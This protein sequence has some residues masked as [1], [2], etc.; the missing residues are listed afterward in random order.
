MQKLDPYINVD[1]GTMNP[2]QHGEVFVTDDKGETD[3][4][5][6]HYE[7]FVDVPLT[8]RSNATTG[9]IYQSVL[10][11]E[12]KGEYLGETVQVIPHITNEIKQRILALANDDVDV[13]ITEVGGTVGDIEILPFLEAIRQFRKDVGRENVFYVHVTLVPYIGPSGEQKTKPTQH[14]VTELRGRGIQPDAIVC[15]SDRPISK[16]LK[17]KISQLCDVPEA[18]IVTAVDADILYEIPLVLHDEGLDDYVCKVLHLDQHEAD[19][20]EWTALVD[21]VRAAQDDVRIGLVGKYINLPD[22]YL[23]V[24]EALKHGGYACGANVHIDWIAADDAEG[25]LAESRLHDLDGIVVPGGFGM[26]GI[27][28]KIEAA[29]YARRNAIPFLGLCLG[30]HCAVIE[31]ARDVCHLENANSSEFDPSTPHPVIDLMDE[32]K[33]VVDMGGTMRLGAYPAKLKA[34]SV[35]REIYGEEVV[36]E[37]HRHRYELNNRYRQVFEEHGMVLSGTSP[38]DLLVEFI[39]LPKQTH[40]FFV[41]TQAHPE[42]KSRPN[43]PHPLFAAFV[44]SALERADGRLPRLPIA[45]TAPALGT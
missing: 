34:G 30:L 36:Y 10:A 17:E 44:R 45:E 32:Q 18:G 28:G 6:G 27:P 25:L 9:S 16:R 43:R 14:S 8:R 20:T 39:E 13:V 5:L 12:R 31:F 41:A 11:K 40:P 29:G 35:A 24:V 42:F 19:L 2:Y 23:S 3:L 38:D 26:R 22:A 4:D 15:R 1:P 37:R 7:R 33:A 21:R